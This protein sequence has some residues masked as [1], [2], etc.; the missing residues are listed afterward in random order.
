MI[1]ISLLDNPSPIDNANA[2]AMIIPLVA[3]FS[4]VLKS[5]LSRPIVVVV[6]VVVVVL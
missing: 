2:V 4:V 3:S 6:V 5:L 1:L